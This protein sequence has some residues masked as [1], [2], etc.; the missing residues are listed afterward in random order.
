MGV[1]GP[2]FYCG[3]RVGLGLHLRM[4]CR[5]QGGVDFLKISLPT[6]RAEGKGGHTG[7]ES[8]QQSRRQ[9][10]SCSELSA[11]S[12]I[13]DGLIIWRLILPTHCQLRFSDQSLN[14]QGLSTPV[15]FFVGA[16]ML[17]SFLFF[18]CTLQFVG[19]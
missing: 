8:C 7:A 18:G 4:P 14:D 17:I 15:G 6:G 5:C 3:Y 2:G 19:S 16:Y 10:E 11:S 12:P 13:I 9:T 1:S